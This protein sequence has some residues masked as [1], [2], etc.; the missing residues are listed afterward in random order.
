MESRNFDMIHFDC[1]WNETSDCPI[2]NFIIDH[3]AFL[4]SVMIASDSESSPEL[5]CKPDFRTAVNFERQ[6]NNNDGGISSRCCRFSL[7]E[8]RG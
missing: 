8:A 1:Q 3:A 7:E 4:V 5:G 2:S 6:L